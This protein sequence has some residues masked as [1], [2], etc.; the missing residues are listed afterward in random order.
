[1]VGIEI[2]KSD[3]IAVA[4]IINKVDNSL[5]DG[6][7]TWGEWAGLAVETP[8]LFKIAKSYPKAK[9]EFKDLSDAEIKEL[10]DAFAIEFDLRN[11]VAE[12]KV[13]QILEVVAAI[14]AAFVK[15]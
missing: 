15:N 2:L 8:K 6:K 5:E 13:E 9:E 7:I 10:T 1:M 11:D 4:K 14:A 3:L 12:Q